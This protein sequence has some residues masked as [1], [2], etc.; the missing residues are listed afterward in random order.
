[1]SFAQLQ[2][3]TEIASSLPVLAGNDVKESITVRTTGDLLAILEKNPPRSFKMM[4]TTCGHLGKYLDL[5]GDQIP[6][7]LIENKKRGFRPFLEGRRYAETSV[8]SYVYQQR[9]L[10][11]AAMRHGWDPD[12]HPT[13]VWKPLLELAVEERLTDIVRHFARTLKYPKEVTKEAVD[14]WGEARIRDGLMFTTVATK[15]NQFWRLLEKTGWLPSTPVHMLKFAPY[16][17]PLEEMSAKL[18]EDI[19][20]VLKWKM[21]EF[22]RNR[23]KFGKIRAVTANNNRLILQQLTG[24]VVKICGGNP[25]SLHEL[26]QQD[27]IEGFIEWAINDRHIKGRSVQGRLAGVLAIVKY[28]PLF[29]GQDFTWFKTLLDSIPI[30]DDSERTKRKAAKY[31]SYDELE[32]IPEKISAYRKAYEKNRHK[33]LVRVAQL[34]ME[35]LMFRWYLVFPWRQRNL[36]ECRISGIAPNLF[37][38]RIPS[39]TEID[40]PDWIEEEE[41]KDPAA[42]FWQISFSPQG[43]KTHISVDLL[44]PRHLIQPLEEYLAE[45]RPLLLNGNDPGTLFVTSRGKSMRPDQVGKV[46]GHWTTEFASNRTTPHMIRDSVAYKW[47][48]E[49]PKD[50]LTLSKILWHKNV[51]TTIQIYASRFNESSGTCAMEAWLDQR[52]GGGETLRECAQLP[53]REA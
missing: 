34:F 31:V 37:K 6:F 22:A 23:P 15:K 26:I 52:A 38:A 40:K 49:H 53:G 13:D 45:Y 10:L 12:G 18:R 29:A 50:Y 21:A 47:L 30:E 11:K 48:K 4:R 20:T 46:V 3:G 5:P 24:Y 39:I 1:M 16:G 2:I 28:H 17:I 33:D 19:Q 32:A 36:R 27:N 8:R 7:D 42:E 14:Q 44:L 41:A 9:S 43:T 35:E 51:Q 25:Q